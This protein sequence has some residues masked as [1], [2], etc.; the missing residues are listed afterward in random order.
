M[1]RGAGGVRIDV[2]LGNCRESYY[3]RK[4]TSWSFVVKKQFEVSCLFQEACY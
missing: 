1:L 2:I 3:E 4:M